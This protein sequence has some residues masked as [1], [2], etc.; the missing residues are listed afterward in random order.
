MIDLLICSIMILEN[1]R[2]TG[3]GIK[4]KI[5]TELPCVLV[6]INGKNIIN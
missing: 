2:F 5:S 3:F 6:I 1:S 4:Y